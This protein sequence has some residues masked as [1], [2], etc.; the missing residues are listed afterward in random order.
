M[1][2][3]LWVLHE[4]SWRW[5]SSPKP[6]IKAQSYP[7]RAVEVHTPHF[8]GLWEAAIKSMKMHLRH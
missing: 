3:T 8:G 7:K 6:R 5:L 4:R 2:L 1:G